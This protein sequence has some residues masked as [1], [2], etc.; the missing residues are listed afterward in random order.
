M[1]KQWWH[2]QESQ[3]ENVMSALAPQTRFFC[4]QLQQVKVIITVELGIQNLS[5]KF[6]TVGNGPSSLTNEVVPLPA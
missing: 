2:G 5:R 6:W 4:Q 1:R 3:S